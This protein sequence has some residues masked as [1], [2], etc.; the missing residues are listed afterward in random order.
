M[1]NKLITIRCPH[2]NMSMCLA[3][4]ELSDVLKRSMHNNIDLIIDADIQTINSYKTW[5]RQYLKCRQNLNFSPTD[6]DL[7][8]GLHILELCALLEF[9]RKY[10]VIPLYDALN[11]FLTTNE[12]SVMLKR[13]T[14]L[15]RFFGDTISR[16]MY[17]N[18]SDDELKVML[19]KPKF[20]FNAVEEEKVRKE[21]EEMVLSATDPSF[22]F[23]ADEEKARKEFEE[24]ILSTAD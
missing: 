6:N 24:M 12:N 4:V 3:H 2:G 15:K 5:C 1:A 23:D 7:F 8:S 11:L 14:E 10:F 19:A 22:D 16:T 13:I 17:S 21:F 9:S 20:D 18:K